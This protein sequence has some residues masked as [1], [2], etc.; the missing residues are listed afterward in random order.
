MAT[1]QKQQ[2]SQEDDITYHHIFLLAVLLPISVPFITIL[3]NF[4][5]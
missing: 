5:C 3:I 1:D 4:E 2:K